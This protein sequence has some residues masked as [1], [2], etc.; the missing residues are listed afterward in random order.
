MGS[1]DICSLNIVEKAKVI[2][3]ISISPIS[4][5]TLKINLIPSIP[6]VSLSSKKMWEINIIKRIMLS[7]VGFIG[8]NLTDM[9]LKTISILCSFYLKLIF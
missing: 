7:I 1:K 2:K 3:E 4:K 6:I 8:L 9:K 5:R